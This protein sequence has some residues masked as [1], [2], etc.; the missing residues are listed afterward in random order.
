MFKKTYKKS[1]QNLSNNLM[2][3]KTF[4]AKNDYQSRP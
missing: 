3:Q 2:R 1:A 4:F